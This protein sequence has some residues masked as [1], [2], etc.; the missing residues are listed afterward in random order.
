MTYWKLIC[1]SLLHFWRTHLAVLLGVATGTAVLTGALVVGDSVRGSL[2]HLALDRLG[3]IDHVVLADRFF[4]A[5]RADNLQPALAVPATL[6]R[7]TIEQA[8]PK[9]R[10]RAGNVTLLAVNAKFNELG[11]SGPNLPL[12]D[13]AIAL[14]APLAEA[15]S[16]KVDDELIVRV[17][18]P[19]QI[20]ADS[21]LGRKSETS[22]S[23][24]FRVK[25]IIPATGLGAFALR[26]NQ[27]F[28]L[29]AYV[30]PAAI[31]AMLQTS[32]QANAIFVAGAKATA[33]QLL[34][35]LQL[36]LADLGLM[37][38]VAPTGYGNLSSTRMLIEPPA[39]RAAEQALT[40]AG[41]I[42][43][44]TLTYLANYILAGDGKAKIPY[45]TVT[46]IDLVD[47]APLGHFTTADG[48]TIT[49]L[50]DD[51]IVLN[52]WAANDMADQG[53]TLSPGDEIVLEYFEPES[54]HGTVRERTAKF[55]LKAVAE[56]TPVVAD[57]HFTPELPGVTDQASIANWDPPFPYDDRRVRSSKPN[58]QDEAY[59]DEYKAT[60]KA[61]VS[62]SAGRKLWSS[63]FGDTTT[64]RFAKAKAEGEDDRNLLTSAVSLLPSAFNPQELGYQVLPV[65]NWGLA[66]AAGTIPFNALF[67]GFSLFLM[68]AAV[69]LVLLLFR[70]VVES[71][72][73][74]LGLLAALGLRER[75]IG[76][77]LLG[78]GAII[79]ALGGIVGCAA[80]V[81]Y[82]WLMLVGLQTVWLD[83]IR[84]PFLQLYVHPVS[85]LAG[86]ASGVIISIA[87]IAW[88]LRQLRGK[89]PQKLLGGTWDDSLSLPGANQVRSSRIRYSIASFLLLA[90]G[91]AMF[92][93]RQ[94]LSSEAQAGAFFGAGALALTAALIALAAKLRSM[95]P[96][97]NA[98][99][100]LPL[101]QLALRSATRNVR[102]SVLSVGLIAVAT[103]LLAAIS[104]FRLDPASEL[105]GHNSGSG[106]FTLWAESDQPLHYD[107][108]VSDNRFTLG[109]SAD[110]E[111]AMQGAKTFALR[112]QPG[113]DASCLNLYQTSQP[114]AIGVPA[115][116]IERGGFAWSAHLPLSTADES[117]WTLLATNQAATSAEPVPIILDANTAT[118]SLHKQLG[119]TL[120]LL[121]GGSRPFNCRIVGLL[122]NS[123]F[124]GDVLMSEANFL[125]HFPESSGFR[126]FLVDTATKSVEQVRQA[127][128]TALGDYGLDT[129]S[130]A[131]RLADFFAVQNTYLSTF[132]S[133]GALGLLLGTVGLAAAILR[134]VL[135]RRGELALLRACGFRDRRLGRLLLL[136][137]L[138]LLLIGLAIGLACAALAL[139]P[140]WTSGTATT[141]WQTLAL[142]LLVILLTAIMVGAWATRI[143]LRTPLLAALRGN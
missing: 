141:P 129:T 126:L 50:A 30:S 79:A 28:P 43:Q 29:N 119:D 49:A 109:F 26:P 77:V 36:T 8:G 24:R 103:F 142:M 87:T 65:R 10:L 62:L 37:Y 58:D 47:D 82:A 102:R 55:R 63:R 59:W 94:G 17:G 14:N 115:S 33:D 110:E 38:E 53:V 76:R 123:I 60:P 5:T 107:L 93:G 92:W 1:R 100:R 80:G 108:N 135:E 2:R 51:E 127:L 91:G 45:S 20:P 125:R 90:A 138:L 131:N 32:G 7:A 97:N 106:G 118:Y 48:E 133:L 54:T 69:L 121:D 89:S 35:D 4:D 128:E 111:Q 114:R 15:L 41:Y 39:A 136:E 18:Q 122:R 86:A 56:M 19:G 98:W 46:A 140:Q 52:R 57:R 64:L 74:Q 31:D 143:A 34:A 27:Q 139:V 61:F 11:H 84:T 6:V 120:T 44:P 3:R 13:D 99:Q 137:N 101:V 132:Q 117:A 9:Q 71:R 96:R 75:A 81:G 42:V 23:R 16:A 21:P 85:L 83:A 73:S 12:A 25:Q 124:Q 95:A 130:T 104:A 22:R 105:A 40:K 116:M 68:I 134:G 88:A 67:F 72:I 70:L 112:M 66:A 78:E 113:D